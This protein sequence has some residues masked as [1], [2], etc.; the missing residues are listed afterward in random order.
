MG[1][2]C[3]HGCELAWQA[4]DDGSDGGDSSIWFE[5]ECCFDSVVGFMEGFFSVAL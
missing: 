2:R 4:V 1:L 3:V 5:R